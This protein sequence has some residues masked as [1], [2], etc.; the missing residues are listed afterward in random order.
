MHNT[1]RAGS[2]GCP[3]KRLQRVSC[4]HDVISSKTNSKSRTPGIP[5]S[6]AALPFVS[7]WLHEEVD[8]PVSTEGTLAKR[9][10]DKRRMGHIERSHCWRAAMGCSI[11]HHQST[12]PLSG[13]VGGA[14]KLEGGRH[15]VHHNS[16]DLVAR[17]A[18]NPV[19][20]QLRLPL[21]VLV[22][23]DAADTASPPFF[24]RAA[25]FV[26]TSRACTSITSAPSVARC[27]LVRV[28]STRFTMRSRSDLRAVPRSLLLQTL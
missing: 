14:P 28:P 2:A 18:V 3:A 20:A 13:T 23:G 15:H 26:T 4:S 22:R 6:T 1:P 27:S 11:A 17:R 12:H 19:A 24:F 25:S 16:L 9:F 21:K 10:R 7:A 8:N 5:L